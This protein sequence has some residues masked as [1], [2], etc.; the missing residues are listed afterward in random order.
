MRRRLARIFM[1]MFMVA[2]LLTYTA[3]LAT[4]A[5]AAPLNWV[6]ANSDGFGDVNN[7]AGY[8]TQVYKNHLYIGTAND[9]TGT[10]IWRLNDDNSWSQINTDGF[11]YASNTTAYCMA[12]YGNSL[13]VGVWGAGQVWAYDGTAWSQANT[14]GFG[15][16]NNPG[17]FSMAVYKNRLY[18]CTMNQAQGCEVWSYDGSTPWSPSATGGFDTPTNGYCY[19]MATYNGRLYAG[20]MNYSTGAEIWELD[21]TT[22]EQVNADGFGDVNNLCHSLAEYNGNLYAGTYNG[23]TGSE[24]W[25][26]N[27]ATWL[28]VNSDGYG[29]AANVTSRSMSV[30]N[31]RLYLGTQ[32]SGGGGVWSYDGTTWEM[33]NTA[34]F[35]DTNNKRCYAIAPF[36]QRLYVGTYNPTT[37]V[38][39]WKNPAP[40]LALAKSSSPPGAVT[41]GQ[42]ITYTLQATNSGDAQASGCTLTDAIPSY[43]DYVQ[44]STTLNGTPVPDVGGTTPLASGFS[45]NSSGQPSGTIVAGGEA[46]V[47]FMVQVRNDVPAGASISNTGT[48]SADGQINKQASA[49]NPVAAPALALTKTS[50][51]SDA[52][53]RGQVITYTLQATNSGTAQATACTMTDAVPAYTTY[54]EHSTTLNGNLIPDVGGTTPLA[55]GLAVNSQGQAAGVISAG[56]EA[57]VTFR[58][59]V[60]SDLPVGASIRNT[61]TLSAAGLPD[62]EASVINP[63]ASDLPTIWYFA[64]GSTQPG[65][66]E[67]LLLSNMEDND[68]TVTITYITDKGVEKQFNHDLPAHSRRTVFVNAEMPNEVGLAAIVQGTWGF[69]CERASY[70]NHNKIDGGHQ[71]IGSTAP[72]NDL[73]FAEGFTG[74]SASPFDEWILVLNPDTSA[75]NLH[76]TYMFPGGASQQKDYQVA[77]RS[78]FSINVDHEVG[79]GHEV[80][81]RIESD[82]AI[83]AERAMYFTYQ[84]RYSGGHVGRASTETRNDWY[85]AEGYT[86]WSGSLFDEYILVS[87]D[88]AQANTVQV[89]FMFPDGSTQ[90]NNFTAAPMSRLTVYADACVGEGKMISA[91]VHAELPVVVERAMY[92]DY[93]LRWQG[94]SNCLGTASPKSTLYF[95][96][97]Y[98]GNPGSQFET[99]LLIQNTS[100]EA[101]TALVDY[102]LASGEVVQ[103]EVALA[104]S[105]RT[106]IYANEVLGRQSLEF[107]MR[108]RSKDGSA[109]LLAERAMYFD[110]MGSFGH[111]QGGDDVAG[112]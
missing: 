54:V 63:S 31:N 3:G 100:A 77:G 36:N 55:S 18:A 88:S 4:K 13:Y 12:V 45:V 53:T 105:S 104:P 83:V 80:S 50:D 107:S 37:G 24:I 69:I 56:A 102:F 82:R 96:E 39:V 14:N 60:A 41:R 25:R 11:G 108:V 90:T 95:A 109:S 62:Q 61:A 93:R 52:V 23:V 81:T 19:S 84:G 78:R 38:E 75:A 112:Y 99:W 111:A 43:S 98:T 70:F 27:G 51:P 40:T 85:L 1:A 64:E 74:T 87:N 42:V 94:G 58:A 68:I 9:I 48:L 66:D 97:G 76:V 86:G 6:Q 28:Q 10:E 32:N 8:S 30:F 65:F 67:Y 29:S 59:Q 35:G 17:V 71:A 7:R 21:E 79:E 33:V 15:N 92:F 16:P 89:T 34:G 72:A 46:D 47:T 110:Y 57:V 20:T 49:V 101:K 5:Y 2:S 73:F 103:Q 22:W 106:T 91:H 26:Y 44:N